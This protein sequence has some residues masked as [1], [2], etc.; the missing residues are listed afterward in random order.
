MDACLKVKS[1]ADVEKLKKEMY[2]KYMALSHEQSD[3]DAHHRREKRVQDAFDAISTILGTYSG[4]CEAA[5]SA[6]GAQ[7][8]VPYVAI[9]VLFIVCQSSYTQMWRNAS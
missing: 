2:A 9:S 8:E 7:A 5:R 6:A 3:F 1:I 4:I